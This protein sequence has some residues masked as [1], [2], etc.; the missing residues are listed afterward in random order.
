MRLSEREQEA[1]RETILAEAPS[2]VIFLYGS[3]TNDESRGGDIDPYIG[4]TLDSGL[5][6]L[7]AYLLARLWERL[8]PQRMDFLIHRRGRPII[9]FEAEVHRSEIGL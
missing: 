8:G 9:P 3:R 2:P 4:T 7:K 1:I 5:P 6:P